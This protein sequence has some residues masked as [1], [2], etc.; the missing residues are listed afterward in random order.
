MRQTSN[1]KNNSFIYYLFGCYLNSPR[2][3]YKVSMSER[4]TYKVQKPGNFQ[5]LSSDG[6][7]KDDNNNKNRS[8]QL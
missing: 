3:N 5:H 6:G 4:N 7:D 8:Y 2:A 1:N